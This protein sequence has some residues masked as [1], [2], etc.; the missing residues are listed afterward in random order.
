LHLVRAATHP[1]YC[2]ENAPTKGEQ[3]SLRQVGEQ[4]A[5][6]EGSD[7]PRAQQRDE[8]GQSARDDQR[9]ANRTPHS[10]AAPAN[11]HAFNDL[12]AADRA[13]G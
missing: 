12:E 1:A 7:E 4:R 10:V 11:R 13:P 8:E 9:D 3:N 5:A 6:S 2:S